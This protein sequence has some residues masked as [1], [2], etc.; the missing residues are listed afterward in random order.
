MPEFENGA[1]ALSDLALPDLRAAKRA[2]SAQYLGDK[3]ENAFSAFAATSPRPADNVVGVGIGEKDADGNP[4]GQLAVK[5]Y[6][7]VKLPKAHLSRDDM[8]PGSIDGVP[9]DVEEVGIFR[10]FATLAPL[11][12]PPMPDPRIRMRPARPGS[13][14]GFESPNFRMAGTFGAVVTDGEAQYILSNNHVLADENRL[15][16]G[17]P[18]FQQGLLDGGDPAADRIAQLTHFVELKPS[19]LN[20]VDAALAR[21]DDYGQVSP[22]VLFIGRPQGAGDAAL[23]MIVHK[24]GRT[25]SY[26]VGRVTSIETDVV[27]AYEIGQLRFEDQIIIVGATGGSFSAAGD[28]GSLIMQRGTNQGVG[29]L[30]AGSPS[31]TIANHLPAVLGALNVSLV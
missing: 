8:L 1:V 12:A 17:S 9:T 26:T 2:L 5:L 4:S 30:F 24:F 13:S 28:S 22:D 21:V 20:Q 23:D 15:P 31:H 11:A 7:R 29:L 18:I 3:V 10:R 6:V 19:E 16:L 14:I 25:T 27:V